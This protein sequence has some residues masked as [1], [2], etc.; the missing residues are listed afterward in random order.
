MKKI[1][2]ILLTAVI[3]STITA[4]IPV[5]KAKSI[6]DYLKD[7]KFDKASHTYYLLDKKG[8]ATVKF[9]G[10]GYVDTYWK[11]PSK[12][13][14]HKVTKISFPVIDEELPNKV[15]IPKTV[16]S[17]NKKFTDS[18][19]FSD[20]VQYNDKYTKL[21]VNKGSYA[22]KYATDNG[23]PYYLIEEKRYYNSLAVA[24]HIFDKNNIELKHDG[25]V[26]ELPD[27]VYTGK[28]IK[29]KIK[30]KD[31]L[32]GKILKKNKD[33][34]VQYVNNCFPGEGIIILQG[35]NNYLKNP[36]YLLFRIL[37]G[38]SV[39]RFYDYENYIGFDFFSDMF[40]FSKYELRYSEDKDFSTY[41]S[42]IYCDTDCDKEVSANLKRGKTYYFKVRAIV[43]YYTIQRQNTDKLS[44]YYRKSESGVLPPIDYR[45]V[46]TVRGKW[47]DAYSHIW[48]YDKNDLNM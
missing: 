12:I 42:V 32:T 47:S 1:V 25:T 28:A 41:K 40:N 29:P 19:F 34:S 2:T 48:K 38:K 43:D 14:G 18:V 6:V 45:C 33:Y 44:D 23:I 31:N 46:K 10:F 4:I 21:V 9:S 17:V 7:Y 24:T 3:I 8:N 27:Y 30:V 36:I 16:K 15:K 37:P 20:T 13:K 26:F 39:I 35:K 11:I 5:S 22:Q